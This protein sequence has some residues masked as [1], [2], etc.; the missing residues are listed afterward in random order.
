MSM[1]LTHQQ[2]NLLAFIR[3]RTEHSPI[4]PSFR[5]MADFLDLKSKSGIYKLLDR[6]EERGCIRRIS[7]RA[8][9]IEVIDRAVIICP[10]CGNP[11]RSKACRVA[12]N[13]DRALSNAPLQNTSKTVIAPA[14]NGS[15]T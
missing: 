8:R 2:A 10:H 5:E 9:A 6:L 7:K 1:G 11:A 3:A 12:A 15:A 13:L 14:A 4:V